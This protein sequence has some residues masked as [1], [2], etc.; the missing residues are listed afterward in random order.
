MWAELRTRPIRTS[1]RPITPNRLH[2]RGT[3]CSGLAARLGQLPSCPIDA[4]NATSCGSARHLL[5]SRPTPSAIGTAWDRKANTMASWPMRPARSFQRPSSNTKAAISWSTTRGYRNQRTVF[6]STV[7]CRFGRQCESLR[8][9]RS[10]HRHEARQIAAADPQT[11]PTANTPFGNAGQAGGQLLSAYLAKQLMN[12]QMAPQATSQMQG[13][14]GS[15][16]GGASFLQGFKACSI[17]A[18]AAQA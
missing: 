7:S 8:Q 18:A 9:S 12:R 6:Q 5:A 2:H 16:V 14:A 4:S 11:N 3:V 13:A 15:N 17:L 1:L 10:C